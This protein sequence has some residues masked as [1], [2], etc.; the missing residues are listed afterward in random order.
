MGITND[1]IMAALLDRTIATKRAQ[2]VAKAAKQPLPA[3][4]P[5]AGLA[6]P[7][8][9]STKATPAR[10]RA[11]P[12]STRGGL[13]RRLAMSAAEQVLPYV[14]RDVPDIEA[15][16]TT[17]FDLGHLLNVLVGGNGLKSLSIIT[18]YFGKR[19]LAE[20]KEILQQNPAAQLKLV[21][22]SRFAQ[23]N[24]ALWAAARQLKREFPKSEIAVC[25]ARIRLACL[26]LVSVSAVID[27]K[28]AIFDQ[29][30]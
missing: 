10:K 9:R 25:D 7:L 17:G 12:A 2:A 21:C 18:T 14:P 16:I 26:H 1:A 5:L 22:F 4:D 27:G 23:R 8:A 19:A 30:R 11:R 3:G 29:D 20:V 28:R 24:A 13:A 15:L 6:P